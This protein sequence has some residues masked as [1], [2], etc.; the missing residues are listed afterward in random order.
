MSDEAPN[1]APA[2]IPTAPVF[3]ETPDGKWFGGEIPLIQVAEGPQG[4]PPAV[5]GAQRVMVAGQPA[6][7]ISPDTLGKLVQAASQA[8]A[9]KPVPT[10]PQGQPQ[11]IAE[12][13]QMVPQMVL[14]QML[15]RMVPGMGGGEKSPLINKDEAMPLLEA[16]GNQ[17]VRAIEAWK[18]LRSPAMP[19]FKIG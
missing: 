19:A 8:Q 3:M 15:Q 10:P 16:I 6:Y 4:A 7:L 12:M 17:A 2:P 18:G 13:M 5:Q 11:G 9:Q 14:M 1:V